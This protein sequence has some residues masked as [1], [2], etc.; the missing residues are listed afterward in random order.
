MFGCVYV[1]ACVYVCLSVCKEGCCVGL[2][3]EGGFLRKDGGG[4]SGILLTWVE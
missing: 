2:G 4:L 3:Q 1:C